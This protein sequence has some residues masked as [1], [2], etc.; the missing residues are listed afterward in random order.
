MLNWST[1]S[2]KHGWLYNG[3]FKWKGWAKGSWILVVQ[4]L[5]LAWIPGTTGSLICFSFFRFTYISLDLTLTLATPSCTRSVINQWHSTWHQCYASVTIQQPAND[6]V[7]V[8]H[9]SSFQE[10]A[11][12][13][14]SRVT[15]QHVDDTMQQLFLNK[16]WSLDASIHVTIH[17]YSIW[18]MHPP[19]QRWSE[20]TLINDLQHYLPNDALSAC[21]F[22][23]FIRVCWWGSR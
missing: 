13:T 9:A 19:R 5:G 17:Y 2:Y 22:A 15:L 10:P 6:C 8:R 1:E 14:L 4:Q 18:Y 20:G 3:L 16:D 12:V 23:M 11:K 7:L 21:T